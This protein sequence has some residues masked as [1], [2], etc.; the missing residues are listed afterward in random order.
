MTKKNMETK[1]NLLLEKLKKDAL[2]ENV[3]HVVF[4][5]KKSSIAICT[6]I[7]VEETAHHLTNVAF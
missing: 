7:H 5:K 1:L 2:K 6:F 4:R 3:R